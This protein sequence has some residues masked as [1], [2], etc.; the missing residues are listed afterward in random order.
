MEYF[1]AG[2]WKVDCTIQFSLGHHVNFQIIQML[3]CTGYHKA[4]RCIALIYYNNVHSVDNL[5]TIQFEMGSNCI[6]STSSI[7]P[8]F[9]S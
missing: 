7:I 2:F 5:R 1:S 6:R 4:Y 3:N 8:S 9:L